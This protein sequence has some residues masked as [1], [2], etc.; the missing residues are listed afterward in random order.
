MQCCG[1]GSD[2][3]P[4][5]IRLF[6]IPDP[7]SALKIPDPDAD[8]LP[9]PDPG[10]KKAPDP[11]SGSATLLS[12]IFSQT[13]FFAGFSLLQGFGSGSRSALI[14]VAGSGSAFKLR[15]RIRIQEG[16]NDPQKYK[17]VQNFHVLKCWMF[18]FEG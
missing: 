6:P 16:K 8:F 10:V 9:I 4:S 17:K 14:R 12:C 7:G 18:S 11:G 13:V 1:S 15:I 3:F 5:R 2:F